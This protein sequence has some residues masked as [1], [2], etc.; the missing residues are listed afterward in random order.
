MHCPVIKDA[1]SDA[2]NA[3]SAREACVEENLY[4]RLAEAS[5]SFYQDKRKSR[6]NDLLFVYAGERT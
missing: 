3:A 4:V 6:S 1:S 5:A 2:K